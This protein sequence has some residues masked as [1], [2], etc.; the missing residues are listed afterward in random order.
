[1][2]NAKELKL[3]LMCG[4]VYGDKYLNKHNKFKLFNKN[5]NIKECLLCH[6]IDKIIDCDIEL[7]PYIYI[8]NRICNMKTWASCAGHL[9]ENYQAA[10]ILF[11]GDY[12]DF[13]KSVMNKYNEFEDYVEIEKLNRYIIKDLNDNEL[14]RGYIDINNNKFNIEKA[15]GSTKNLKIEHTYAC[16]IRLKNNINDKELDIE[17]HPL[18]IDLDI[19]KAKEKFYDFIRLLIEE[20]KNLND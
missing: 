16:A 15:C 6:S 18:Y 7:A 17:N 2:N 11:D 10:Y 13:I 8:F 9:E 14:N 3:C 12:Y 5:N 1:M 20:R 4:T 19:L